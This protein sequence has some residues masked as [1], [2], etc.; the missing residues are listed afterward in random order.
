MRLSAVWR[1]SSLMRLRLTCRAMLPLMVAMPAL[2][3]SGVTSLSLTSKPAS[4]QTCAMPL[5]ICPAPTTP[6]FL[7]LNGMSVR[8]TCCRACVPCSKSPAGRSSTPFRSAAPRAAAGR[9]CNI[10]LLELAE[11][12][13]QFGQRLV[14][15]GHQAV[16]GD[17]EDG[18]LLV[19]VD[20]HDHL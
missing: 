7:M 6:I 8:L 4:A 17:L 3:R 15:I 2:I 9:R 20:R 1:S 12:L 14:E 5:P 19:L 18:R 11:L 13:R 16:I 10:S